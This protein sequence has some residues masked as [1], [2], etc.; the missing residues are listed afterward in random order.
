MKRSDVRVG[1][2]VLVPEEAFGL[3]EVPAKGGVMV[4]A[5]VLAIARYWRREPSIVRVRS[6]DGRTA[7]INARYL[8][9]VS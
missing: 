2:K 4:R 6:D 9:S 5:Q 8:E 1:M 7:T 3:F